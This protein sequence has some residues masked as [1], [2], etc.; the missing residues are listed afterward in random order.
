MMARKQHAK[1][2]EKQ[3]AKKESN[4]ARRKENLTMLGLGF[5]IEI[6]TTISLKT[7]INKNLG[8]LGREF[9]VVRLL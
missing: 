6:V 2:K 8:G 3:H 5:L 9:L 7:S 4:V 1:K